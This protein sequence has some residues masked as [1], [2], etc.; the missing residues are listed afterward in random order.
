MTTKPLVLILS[1]DNYSFLWPDYLKLLKKYWKDFK[2]DILFNSETKSIQYSDL[3]ILTHDN[4]YMGQKWGE[5]FYNLLD[6]IQ[7]N[8]LIVLMDDHFIYKEVHVDKIEELL[9]F[10]ILHE[11]VGYISLENQP[12]KKT[13]T[14]IDYLKERKLFQ[15]Y[16]IS[17][18]SG[19]WRKNYLMKILKKYESPWEFEINGSFRSNFKR[20]KIYCV[21]DSIIPTHYGQLIMRGK[22]DENLADYFRKHEKLDINYPLEKYE[23]TE[24][25][26]KNVLK[27]FFTK[28]K[29][30]F[31]M[32]ISLFRR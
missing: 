28:L 1:N 20:E 25:I 23:K 24:K 10:L 6:N 15:N 22:L 17:L 26:N 2:F 13:K 27:S 12:G 4:D 3:N 5:R 19:I 7:Y 18:Q 21:T 29:Y 16:R 32:F 31:N 8:Y 9:K 30:I 11:N 14:N